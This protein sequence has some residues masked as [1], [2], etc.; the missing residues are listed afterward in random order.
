[1]GYRVRKFLVFATGINGIWDIKHRKIPD[2]S[3]KGGW[4]LRLVE[5]MEH[6]PKMFQSWSLIENCFTK[7][8]SIATK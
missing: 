5:S 8:C 2:F 6:D 4:Y 7:N 3:S 1:M